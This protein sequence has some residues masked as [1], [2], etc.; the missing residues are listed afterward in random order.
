MPRINVVTKALKDQGNC[1]RCHTP[2]PA[3]SGYRHTKVG[4][5]GPKIV[6]CLSSECS[7]RPSELTDSKLSEAYAAQEDA[8]DALGTWSGDKDDLRSILDEC[9]ER[10]RGVAEEYRDASQNWG[11]SGNEEWDARADA[12][13][14]AAD[15]LDEVDLDDVEP[16]TTCP[17]VEGSECDGG[18]VDNPEHD[19]DVPDSEETV[20]CSRCGGTGEIEDAE[21]SEDQIEE[22][23]SMAQEAIDGLEMEG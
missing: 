14:A 13:E 15:S 19:P 4:F 22:L 3:G 20:A 7:F 16:D 1:G 6:R 5:R 2:L 21:L 11:D 23:S 17:G 18:Q 9:A 12:L 10:I 8:Q